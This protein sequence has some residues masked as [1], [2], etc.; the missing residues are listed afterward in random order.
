LSDALNN[1]LLHI[2]NFFP[3]LEVA[4]TV[5]RRLP[6]NA[7]TTSLLIFTSFARSCAIADFIVPL[8]SNFLLD[9]TGGRAQFMQENRKGGLKLPLPKKRPEYTRDASK[10]REFKQA[11]FSFG[12]AV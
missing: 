12:C 1:G 5:L 11:I 10:N 9:T 6:N 4:E 2:S 7:R 3:R 8:K